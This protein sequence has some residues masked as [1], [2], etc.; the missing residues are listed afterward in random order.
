MPAEGNPT[1]GQGAGTQTDAASAPAPVKVSAQEL[2]EFV[3]RLIGRHGTAVAALTNIAGEQLRYRKRAQTAEARANELQKKLPSADAVVIVGDEAKAYNDLK[4]KGLT[5]DKVPGELKKHEDLQASMATQA[6]EKDLS[7][8]VGKKYDMAVLKRLLGEDGIKKLE[9]RSV[10]QMKE[11][12]SGVE[13][14]KIPYI[15]LA[16]NK[17][18][19]ALDTYVEREFS[20]FAEVLKPKEG[21]TSNEEAPRMPK[22]APAGGAPLRGKDAEVHKVVDSQMS[23]FLSPSARRKAEAAETG[24]K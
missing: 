16:D 5:L 7:E 18:V 23:G 20:Q 15:T 1:P 22:Q 17:T 8:T 6:R 2:D 4:A 19:E 3:T 21:G 10:N 13:T 9:F 14:V 11:D 24:A 12:K